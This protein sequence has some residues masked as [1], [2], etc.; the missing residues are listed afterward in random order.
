MWVQY[1]CPNSPN[2][3]KT[4][5]HRLMEIPKFLNHALELKVNQNMGYLISVKPIDDMPNRVKSFTL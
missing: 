3:S 5:Y 4:I 1:S 2:I